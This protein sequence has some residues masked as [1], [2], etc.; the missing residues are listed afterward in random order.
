MAV[1]L[2]AQEVKQALV[3]SLKAIILLSAFTLLA[4]ACLDLA[5]PPKGQQSPTPTQTPTAT[6]VPTATVVLV[7][8][9]AS[10]T[11]TPTPTASPTATQQPSITI[12]PTT[13]L[14]VVAPRGTVTVGTGVGQQPTLPGVPSS[15][16]PGNLLPGGTIPGVPGANVP[17]AATGASNASPVW[18]CDG[19][20]RIDFVPAVPR[21]GEKVFIYVT[22]RRD[23]AFALLIGPGVSGTAGQP[24]AGGNGLKMLWPFTPTLGGAYAFIDD[25]QR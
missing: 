9:T 8:P 22:A 13:G 14:P 23:R 5:P 21:V 15:V 1:V 19:D 7:S 20:E 10:S 16:Q 4:T 11:V 12:D 17:G 2:R 6:T 25:H 18:G 24:V 3:H